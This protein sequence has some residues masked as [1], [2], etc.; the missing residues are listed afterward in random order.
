MYETRR[1]KNCR[2]ILLYI[3][4]YFSSSFKTIKIGKGIEMGANT[5]CPSINE[6]LKGLVGF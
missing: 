1:E 6:I 2:K 4:C 5:T 3:L